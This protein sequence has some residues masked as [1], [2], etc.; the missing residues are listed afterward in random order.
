MCNLVGNLC[1]HSDS[2]YGALTA[3][4]QVRALAS[5]SGHTRS[6]ASRLMASAASAGRAG[7]SGSSSSSGSGKQA[8]GGSRGLGSELDGAATAKLPGSLVLTALDML[9]AACADA[10]PATRKFAAFAVGN[11]AFHSD[12]LYG[13]MGSS[14]AAANLSAA[15]SDSDEKT[16]ANA[17]GALGNLVRNGA[18][19]CASMCRLGVV[20]RLLHMANTDAALSPRRIALFSLGTMAANGECRRAMMGAKL[21]VTDVMR[22]IKARAEGQGGGSPGAG[23]A[24]AEA[25]TPADDMSLKYLA[26]LRLKLKSAVVGGE[27]DRDTRDKGAPPPGG[28]SSGATARTRSAGAGGGGSGGGGSGAGG[29]SGVA[30]RGTAGAASSSTAAGGSSRR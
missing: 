24:A 21:S 17:A 7:K 10:D 19:L 1:R 26:R 14:A 3:P 6:V 23:S 13:S 30:R 15:L 5:L 25:A 16:R 9:V 8:G 29:T 18:Y 20:E 22:A 11:A 27:R 2:F 28:A 4:I 12:A